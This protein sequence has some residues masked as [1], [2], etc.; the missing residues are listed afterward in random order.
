MPLL[1]AVAAA[2]LELKS[3]YGVQGEAC[4]AAAVVVAAVV[5][6]MSLSQ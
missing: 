3:I 4:V 6:C 2:V 5:A 1:A